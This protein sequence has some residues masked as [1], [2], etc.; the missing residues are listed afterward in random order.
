MTP[1]KPL[2]LDELAD[3][4]RTEGWDVIVSEDVVARRDGPDG[5]W[6]VYADRAGRVRLEV[7]R[8]AGMP[9]GRRVTLDGREY[10]VLRE[11]HEVINVLVT[12]EN[13][14][15]LVQVLHA[16]E[17]IVHRKLWQGQSYT[18]T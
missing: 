12:I 10:R 11:L 16:F 17:D 15:E 18:L 3:I 4:L 9:E 13:E 7:T 5:V 1:Q 8:Q 14:N 2:V 6:N